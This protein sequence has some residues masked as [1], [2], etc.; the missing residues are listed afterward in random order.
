MTYRQLFKL[1]TGHLEFWSNLFMPVANDKSNVG[2]FFKLHLVE[3]QTF[4]SE[5]ELLTE[6]HKI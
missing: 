1:I 5:A 4:F 2:R 6:P 3:L